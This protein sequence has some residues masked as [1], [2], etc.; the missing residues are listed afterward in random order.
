MDTVSF[1][2]EYENGELSREE[3]VEGFQELV[4]SG[5]AWRL[6]GSYGRMAQRFIDSGEVE[7]A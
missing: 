7:A 2:M 5:L 1:L 4:N 6:Q 3:I